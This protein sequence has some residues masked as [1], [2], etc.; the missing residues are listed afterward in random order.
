MTPLETITQ[1]FTQLKTTGTDL[2]KIT[3]AMADANHGG[4]VQKYEF[5]HIYWHPN[6][7]AHEVHG[8]ILN[9]FLKYGGVDVNPSL[10]IRA[11]GF[12][13]SDETNT[14]GKPGRVSYFE[15][16]AIY[17]HPD[18][19]IMGNAV[20][21]DCYKSFDE[22]VSYP[23]TSTLKTPIGEITYVDR[24]CIW[25][26]ANFARVVNMV[27][28]GPQIGRPMIC[29]PVA[30]ELKKFPLLICEL[31]KAEKLQLE[32]LYPGFMQTIWNHNIG[33]RPVLASAR[34]TQ[35]FAVTGLMEFSEIGN[36]SS[37]T[38]AGLSAQAT[39]FSARPVGGVPTT[40][41]GLPFQP[42]QFYVATASL[43]NNA[44]LQD[45][46]LYDLV[47][48]GTENNWLV[49]AAHCIYSKNTWENFAAI[50]ATDLHLSRRLD[51]F[52]RILKDKN[53]PEGVK[54]YNNFNDAFRDLVLY[55][56]KLHGL[57]ALDLLILTGDL[58]DYIFENDDDK[59]SPGN[60]KLFKKIILG[61]SP[62]PD[63]DFF[64]PNTAKTHEELRVPV[65]TTLGNHDYR[66]NAYDLIARIDAGD[67]GGYDLL[68]G[69]WKDKTV[70]QYNSMNL[71]QEDAEAI[72][73][74]D[75]VYYDMNK[76]ASKVAALPT[77]G[78]Y[79][80]HGLINQTDNYVVQL[81]KNKLVMIN[82]EMD[83]GI[84]GA[85]A[86]DA[87]K[88]IF[89]SMDES[90]T[91]F[92]DGNPDSLGFTEEKI[93]MLKRA[94][95]ETGEGTVI[96]GL[97]APPLNI[98]NNEFPHYF[99]ETEHPEVDK[100]LVNGYLLRAD[101][102]GFSQKD[103]LAHPEKPFPDWLRSNSINFKRKSAD[104]FLDYGVS[105][106]MQ[107]DFLKLCQG[108]MG[109][110]KPDLILS[111]HGHKRVE[112]RL[113]WSEENKHL[114][115]YMDFYTENPQE[116]YKSVYNKKIQDYR[117]QFM[118]F[119]LMQVKEKTNVRIF[120]REGAKVNNGIQT[121]NDHRDNVD[122][123][124]SS[125]CLNV[126]PFKNPLNN[127]S[128]A[129]AWWNEHRPIIVQT[130]ALGPTESN[131]R[132]DAKENPERP[133]PAFNGF[134]YIQITKNIISK[135]RYVTMKELR[136]NNFKMPWEPKKQIVSA[137][138]LSTLSNAVTL[139]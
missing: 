89:S 129:A 102:I 1:K 71:V 50:H 33:L 132:K 3:V 35:E 109:T 66:P 87:L 85:N 88:V 70:K 101:S 21:G 115:Y 73:G 54:N 128:N 48:K 103:G 41:P 113:G 2:G 111:G 122:A 69:G 137:I 25:K 5:G 92:V 78:M 117:V 27:L 76:A 96:V 19:G 32:S 39:S 90:E 37:I 123:W 58:V 31:T 46:T 134:R 124:A 84:L 79:A 63:K 126:P 74:K 22:T 61:E 130:A 51:S 34:T 43:P 106:N 67:F 131:N 12:P 38:S 7:G 18:K 93:S 20:W 59:N 16:G 120:I 49:Y 14:K 133:G 136:E 40:P 100:K 47:V 23:A 13:I 53:M 42:K 75:H 77:N 30:T 95:Q 105:K 99:R 138:D 121:I 107:D 64:A 86:K 139:K 6:T 112:Y 8:G 56:N 104:E 57:G 127:A 81:G 28:N 45:S 44:I 60:F 55:A 91:N 116:Y 72:L 24:G 29:T 110:R 17:W 82:T 62:Y 118:S 135:I 15:W 10:G 98:K 68:P 65:F 97:H 80:Y 94:L 36:E 125:S 9:A 11:L 114:R 4:K 83:K 52:R 26:P 119:P 108:L